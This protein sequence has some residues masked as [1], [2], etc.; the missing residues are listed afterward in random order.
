MA[1][2]WKLLHFV[3]DKQYVRHL[4]KQNIKKMS[5]PVLFLHTFYIIAKCYVKTVYTFSELEY[6]RPLDSFVCV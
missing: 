3:S 4:R 2:L 6:V 1:A 5:Q